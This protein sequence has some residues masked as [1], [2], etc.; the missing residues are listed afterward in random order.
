MGTTAQQFGKI[1]ILVLYFFVP[2]PTTLP[3]ARRLIDVNLTGTFICAQAAGNAMIKSNTGGSMA[4]IASM[5]G[6]IVNRPQQQSCTTRLR[7]GSLC[8]ESLSPPGALK[9]ICRATCFREYV[10]TDRISLADDDED[11]ATMASDDDGKALV[12]AEMVQREWQVGWDER[13]ATVERSAS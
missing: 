5:S 8:W 13:R 7:P 11:V 3:R 12:R 6:R 9:H 1:D 2:V 4:L 10:C